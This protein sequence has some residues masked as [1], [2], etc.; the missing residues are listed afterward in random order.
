MSNINVHF[1][2]TGAEV[3]PKKLP[4]FSRHPVNW[5]FVSND[6]DIKRVGIVFHESEC[7][8]FP[9]CTPPNQ[10]ERQLDYH[11]GGSAFTTIYGTAPEHDDPIPKECEYTVYGYRTSGGKE[12]A[13]PMIL[14]TK[15]P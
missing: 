15:E 1:K 8:F 12:I 4:V 7:Q 2:V 9:G 10:C 13:D 3:N 6:P 11:G 5:H 14:V